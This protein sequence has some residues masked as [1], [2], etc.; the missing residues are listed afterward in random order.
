M[1]LCPGP[2]RAQQTNSQL[3]SWRQQGHNTSPSAS[4]PREH[5][6]PLWVCGNLGWG[7]GPR[8]ALQPSRCRCGPPTPE[9]PVSSL[10]LCERPCPPWGPLR[11]A[12]I[13]PGPVPKQCAGSNLPAHP[14][15]HH[16]LAKH[17]CVSFPFLLSETSLS[18]TSL[19]S[20]TRGFSVRTSPILP[21]PEN[22][23]RQ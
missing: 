16:A 20:Q 13:G 7:L 22:S 17:S 8:P 9:C 11:A 3:C 15:Q 19:S 21:H 18:P 1:H 4:S 6:K 2:Q 10:Q 12:V 14:A 5:G 23:R